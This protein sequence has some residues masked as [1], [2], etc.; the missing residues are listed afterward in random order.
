M[1]CDLCDPKLVR[2]ALFGN[3]GVSVGGNACDLCDPM[4]LR[5]ALFRNTGVS[6]GGNIMSV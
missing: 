5:C 3:M 2:C 6:V 1:S 4:L